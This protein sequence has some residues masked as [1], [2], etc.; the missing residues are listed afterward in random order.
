MRAL[1]TSTWFKVAGPPSFR[2]TYSH[3][4]QALSFL[5]RALLPLER[6]TRTQ[7]LSF[8]GRA[9][10]TLERPTRTQALFFLGLTPTGVGQLIRREIG[11]PLA[12]LSLTPMHS[13]RHRLVRSRQYAY[14]D[15]AG[16][17][18]F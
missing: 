1:P 3:P 12:A 16:F 14:Q 7:A 13:L 5:G 8:L 4:R 6:P 10:L 9:L 11:G 18:R 17:L 15:V 2:E